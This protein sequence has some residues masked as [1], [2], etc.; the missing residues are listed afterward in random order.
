MQVEKVIRGGK[1]AILLSPGFGAGWSTWAYDKHK[2]FALFDKRL[3]EAAEAGVRDIEPIV[4]DA[5]GPDNDFYC[6]G[7]R[8]IKVEW[9]PQGTH[10]R[11]NEYDG[12]ESLEEFSISAYHIA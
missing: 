3:V 11:I 10:F 4:E 12:S 7:W 6:G 5:L 2:E 1:V 8:D 9:L